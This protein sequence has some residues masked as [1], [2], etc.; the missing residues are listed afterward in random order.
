MNFSSNTW[1]DKII[2]VHIMIDPIFGGSWMPSEE[3]AG[4]F[5]PD[6]LSTATLALIYDGP[7]SCICFNLSLFSFSL[8]N[9][10]CFVI[11][12]RSRVM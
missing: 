5:W 9:A 7:W 12:P 4:A 11:P 8:A 10:L 6:S 2:H 1:L 3:V